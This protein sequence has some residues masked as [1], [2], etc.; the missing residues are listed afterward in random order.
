MLRRDQQLA[1]WL[2]KWTVTTPSHEWRVLKVVAVRVIV[3]RATTV[4][5][6]NWQERF[7][8]ATAL[9]P[10]ICL[11]R[12]IAGWGAWLDSGGIRSY[13]ARR[14]DALDSG[15][16]SRMSAYINV[17]APALPIACDVQCALR[18]FR[19]NVC[20]YVCA[21]ACVCVRS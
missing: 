17:C 11:S 10:E 21:R 4:A 1:N 19:T 14:N 15:G 2:P 7:E 6:L 20:V 9:N 18:R 5:C 13:A 3:V 16:V 12:S 8:F